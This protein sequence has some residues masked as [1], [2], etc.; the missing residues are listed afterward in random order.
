MLTVTFGFDG[1]GKSRTRRPLGYAYSVMPPRLAL[2]WTPRGR[3][4]EN[5]GL[6]ERKKGSEQAQRL[7]HNG[8]RGEYS[9]GQRA[10]GKGQRAKS[11]LPS[12]LPFALCSL[13]YRSPA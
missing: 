9:E 8:L 10:E 13:P 1:S 5:A 2:C 4:C 7:A 12:P 3:V 6:A 11:P